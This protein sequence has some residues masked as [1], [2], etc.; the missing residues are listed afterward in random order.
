MARWRSLTW[1][2]KIL[3]VKAM[4]TLS[5]YACLLRLLPFHRLM[6]HSRTKAATKPA[7]S[8]KRIESVVWAITTV[9]QRFP[10]LFTCLTQALSA[11]QLLDH[12]PDI[13]LCIGV[14]KSTYQAFY[15]HAWVLHQHTIILGGQIS[16]EFTP[17]TTWN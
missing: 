14:Q 9:S 10:R 7:L 2:K 13:H 4:T 12:H 16:G 17:I 6:Q 1:E 11:K 8:E 5:G 3:L 15:A